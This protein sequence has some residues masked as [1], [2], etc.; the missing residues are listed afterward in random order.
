MPFQVLLV[1]GTFDSPIVHHQELLRRKPRLSVTLD[2]D[3]EDTTRM[4]PH[5]PRRL[6]L[7]FAGTTLILMVG[8]LLITAENNR[9]YSEALM[10]V[11]TQFV[12][13]NQALG[14]TIQ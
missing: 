14:E 4:R 2:V 8:V 10:G 6:S 7:L 12:S 11:A 5:N 3:S 1:S 13:T 9:K